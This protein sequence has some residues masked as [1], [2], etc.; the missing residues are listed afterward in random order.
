MECCQVCCEKINKINHKKVKCPFCDLTSCRA[1]SQRYILSSFEDPHCMGCKT[2]WNRE[3]IDSFCTMH[4]RNTELRKHR[5]NVLFERE[6][7]LMPSTQ[8]EVERILKI[9]KI[10]DKIRKEQEKFVHILQNGE[11]TQ[12]E[13]VHV[14]IEELYRELAR[15]RNMGEI[16][17]DNSRKFI[18][19]CPLE[20]CKGFLNEQ[21]YCGLCDTQFCE[22]CSEKQHENHVCDPGVVET[23]TLLNKDSKPCPKCGIVIQKINGCSQ[24]WCVECHTAFNWRT[25]EI[26]NGRIHNPHFI[27]FKKKKLLSR[28]HG[29]IP[30]GGTPTYRELR[31][32]G[33]PISILNYAITIH[34]LERSILFVQTEIPDNLNS[35]V[36][37]MLNYIDEKM[38]KTF[39]QR[40]EKFIEKNRD[41]LNIYELLIHTGGDLL[42]Q[43]VLN[44]DDFE[45]IIQTMKMLFRYGND[46]F[47]SL[48]KRYKCSLPKNISV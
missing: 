15:L 23:M 27:E 8:P 26:I 20:N 6:K 36:L 47:E 10:K 32:A 45:E 44:I 11:I 2:R 7:A 17:I 1:C 38:F 30:C 39:L 42:R 46:I 24:M 19:Q 16:S 33:A 29:D 25:G 12:I 3:F 14:K 28:E 43:Y 22:K 40:Q 48:R 9:R 4:F 34:D 35:R 41:V 18:R 5:E 37:Y 13:R 21:W 31:E